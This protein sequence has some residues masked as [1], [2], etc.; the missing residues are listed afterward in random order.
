[1]SEE[2]KDL[3]CP[4]RNGPR[5]TSTVRS[6]Q[7]QNRK[8]CHSYF[9]MICIT[10]SIIRELSKLVKYLNKK[11][12]TRIWCMN[13]SSLYRWLSICRRLAILDIISYDSIRLIWL[14]TCMIDIVPRLELTWPRSGKMAADKFIK[15][16]KIIF[17]LFIKNYSNHAMFEAVRELLKRNSNH[18]NW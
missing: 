2:N 15:K 16:K 13:R 17:N 8:V 4:A 9:L 14:R 10:S 1:M 7:W 12:M 5:F 18:V 3:T 11:N 6:Y